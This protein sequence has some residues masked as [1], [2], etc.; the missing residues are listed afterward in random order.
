MLYLTK[1]KGLPHVFVPHDIFLNSL[2]IA[3][4]SKLDACDQLN[5]SIQSDIKETM[6]VVSWLNAND[7]YTAAKFISFF[8]HKTVS[9]TTKLRRCRNRREEL[10]DAKILH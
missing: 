9:A 10:S 8:S 4:A 5:V 6:C 7:F 1:I 3:I 2:P